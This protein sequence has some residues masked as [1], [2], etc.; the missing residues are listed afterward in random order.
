MKKGDIQSLPK[1]VGVL[2]DF[3]YT[4]QDWIKTLILKVRPNTVIT[5]TTGGGMEDILERLAVLRGDLYYKQ[6]T[7]DQWEEQV[8]GKRHAKKL[9]DYLFLSYIKFNKGFLFLFP[10]KYNTRTVGMHYSGRMQDIIILAHKM[11]IPY[12]IIP[13]DEEEGEDNT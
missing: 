11:G 8:K 5:T 1:V 4:K 13:A 12:D 6:F 2:A 3:H 10:A 9:Q 7:I